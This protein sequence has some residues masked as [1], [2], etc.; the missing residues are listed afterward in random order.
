MAAQTWQ[1]SSFSGDA[2]NCIYLAA[3]ADGGI[4]IRE[5]DEP[6]VVITTTA[7]RLRVFICGVKAGEFDHLMQ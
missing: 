2:A 6:D 3:A 1:K 7:E 4:R 5:S